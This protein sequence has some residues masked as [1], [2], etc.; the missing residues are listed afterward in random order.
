MFLRAVPE[1]NGLAELGHSAL[2][3]AGN[4]VALAFRKQ[5]GEPGLHSAIFIKTDRASQRN[6][7]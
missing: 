1:F 5:R 6:D 4:V 2:V 3:V 7:K